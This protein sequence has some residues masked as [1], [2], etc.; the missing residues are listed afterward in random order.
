MDQTQDINKQSFKTQRKSVSLSVVNA[1]FQ[2][3]Q[4]GYGWGPGIRDHYLVHCVLS[5]RGSYATD[6]KIFQ[7]KPGELFLIYPGKTCS[8]IADEHDPWH[9]AWVGFNGQDALYLLGQAGFS[10]ER[11]VVRASD[12]LRLGKL[13][14]AVYDGRGSRV[15]DTARMTGRVYEFLADLIDLSTVQSDSTD[16]PAQQIIRSALEFVDGNYSHP[17]S[18]EDIAR[19]TGISRSGLYRS[20][21]KAFGLA[22]M[23]YVNRHRIE[24]ACT[25]LQNTS[26]PI[27]E[28]ARSTGFDDPLYFSRAFK[29]TIGRSPKQYRKDQT[30]V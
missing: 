5:G 1:G 28:I 9:Y 8:Y 29:H 10:T 22:P 2:R 30:D 20:F 4:P 15:Q 14:Q 26:S 25:L 3:C 23:Q 21:Q 7:V 11:P 24:R 16:D 12:P 19:Y 13:L 6:G 27:A 17:I 18:V